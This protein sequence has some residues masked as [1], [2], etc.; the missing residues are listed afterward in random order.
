MCF[1]VVG[2]RL[3][4]GQAQDLPVLEL[5]LRECAVGEVLTPPNF[6]LSGEGSGCVSLWVGCC[7]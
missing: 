5:S 4:A 3:V 6:P 2:R 1:V 7:E